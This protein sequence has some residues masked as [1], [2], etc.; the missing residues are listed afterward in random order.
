M[1]PRGSLLTTCSITR[2][3]LLICDHFFP[4]LPLPLTQM[5]SQNLSSSDGSTQHTQK[6]QMEVLQARTASGGSLQVVRAQTV[7]TTSSRWSSST[8]HSE[9]CNGTTTSTKSALTTNG[10]SSHQQFHKPL[11]NSSRLLVS[12]CKSGVR[13]PRQGL[14]L[15]MRFGAPRAQLDNV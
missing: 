13:V 2:V 9:I 4:S 11:I 10:F 14:L 12:V 3:D 15:S 8:L 5:V 1:S 6:K 7:Q